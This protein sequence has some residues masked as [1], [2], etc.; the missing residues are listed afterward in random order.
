M[1]YKRKEY[2][3]IL[4]PW[5]T[6]EKSKSKTMDNKRKEYNLIPYSKAMDYKRKEYNLILKP[7]ITK[8]KSI[9]LF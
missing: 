1:G 5:I 2:N 8:E 9:T 4:I 3:L 6:K 7:W